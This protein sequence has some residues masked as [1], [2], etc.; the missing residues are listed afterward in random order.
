MNP[1]LH[2]FGKQA[3]AAC[4]L[5]HRFLSTYATPIEK[6]TDFLDDAPEPE[7]IRRSTLRGYFSRTLGWL[8]SISKLN[9]PSDVQAVTVAAR[10]LFESLIDVALLHLDSASQ[11]FDKVFAW[12]RSAILSH[13]EKVRRFY[14]GK[15]LPPE[16]HSNPVFLAGPEPA[17]IRASRTRWWGSPDRHPSRWTG[18]KLHVDAKRAQEL[19]VAAKLL[20]MDLHQFYE[21]EYPLICWGTHG[22]GLAGFRSP[23][24]DLIA[25][26]CSLRLQ[27]VHGLALC[28]LQ[29]ILQELGLFVQK[30]FADF[31]QEAQRQL[32]TITLE[33]TETAPMA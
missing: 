18:N 6:T 30:E 4:V 33:E 32:G 26:E 27:R 5:T 1:E 31:S 21:L 16:H 22:S 20:G 3:F 14:D 15:V 11:P 19:L 25:A 9:E 2:L 8:S 29:I 13:A 10:T 28:I 24:P 23:D 12:E 17:Q 7:K